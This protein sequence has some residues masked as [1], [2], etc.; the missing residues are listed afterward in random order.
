MNT[1]GPVTQPMLVNLPNI[2]KR[3]SGEINCSEFFQVIL[4]PPRELGYQR[5]SDIG[6]VNSVEKK[7][8]RNKNGK[9]ISVWKRSHIVLGIIAVA[10]LL[11]ILTVYLSFKMKNVENVPKAPSHGC[12]LAYES[13]RNSNHVRL[14]MK[15]A[16][17]N[18]C[19]Y[20]E[21]SLI[22]DDNVV[23]I[24]VNSAKIVCPENVKILQVYPNS[25]QPSHYTA[26]FDKFPSIRTISFIAK[27]GCGQFMSL[28][29]KTG[30]ILRHVTNLKFVEFENCPRVY[31]EI[32]EIFEFPCLQEIEFE[33]NK[34]TSEDLGI[35]RNFS[36]ISS[37]L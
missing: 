11:V 29:R 28:G 35:I 5:T 15:S 13:S 24:V 23:K 4:I 10:F 16:N 36:V 2:G 22:I 20:S 12:N 27:N 26:L 1:N 7:P 37:S 33:C 32:Q 17:W 18:F 9:E 21:N 14:N 30:I 34:F 6:H 8:V 19:R 3:R 31:Q 25:L